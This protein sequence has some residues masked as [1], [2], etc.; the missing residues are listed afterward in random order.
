VNTARQYSY[1]KQISPE[2]LA[3]LGISRFFRCFF[4]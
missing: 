4:Q 1:T 3:P 2:G